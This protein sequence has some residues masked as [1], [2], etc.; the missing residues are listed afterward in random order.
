M[1]ETA[2]HPDQPLYI[3]DKDVARFKPNQIIRALV[4]EEVI[5]LNKIALRDFPDEDQQ[6]LA[7]LMG[8]S[9]GGYSELSYVSDESY[10]RAVEAEQRLRAGSHD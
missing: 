1:T 9:V 3:D 10:D 8:Y 6:Q 4:Y 5:D 2:E 7:Q